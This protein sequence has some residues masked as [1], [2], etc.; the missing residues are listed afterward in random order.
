MPAANFPPPTGT[1]P[2]LPAGT[3]GQWANPFPG[4]FVFV[5]TAAAATTSY[6]WLWLLLGLGAAGGIGYY[7][8]D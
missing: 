7:L 6:T 2:N 1:P 8:L 5:P 3:A 4:Y